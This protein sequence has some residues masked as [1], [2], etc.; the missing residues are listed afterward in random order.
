MPPSDEG[1]Q[2][3]YVGFVTVP[4]TPLERLTSSELERDRASEDGQLMRWLL[5]HLRH[6]ASRRPQAGSKVGEAV[7]HVLKLQKPG[8][9]LP[10]RALRAYY[11]RAAVRFL[12]QSLREKSFDVLLASS[13]QVEGEEAADSKHL[14]PEDE[15]SLH[16][17]FDEARALVLAA[18]PIGLQLLHWK[19]VDG[20]SGSALATKAFET[21]GLQ[22]SQMYL[23]LTKARVAFEREVKRR[24]DL[25]LSEEL[26]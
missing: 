11:L 5:G 19:E 23:H 22:K 25:S 8:G 6:I 12:F 18:H 13:S 15:V 17:A 20:L 9:Q 3:C 24:L 26:P 7:T 1:R 10:P 14:S 21:W 4:N 16:R 2:R